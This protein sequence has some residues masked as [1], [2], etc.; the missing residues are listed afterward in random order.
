MADRVFMDASFALALLNPQD[1]LHPVALGK[2]AVVRSALR[3]VTTTAVLIEI[4]DAMGHPAVRTQAGRFIE[5]SMADPHFEVV[6]VGPDLLARA[7]RLYMQR[8]DKHWSLTDC[9]SFVVMS[10]RGLVRALSADHHFEQAGF[11][12][13]MRG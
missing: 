3:V 7:V 5:S 11:V 8:L 4:C 13:L 2:V 1:Q 6:H 9:I 12:A 10:E